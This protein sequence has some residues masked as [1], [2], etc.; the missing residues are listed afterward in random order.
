EHMRKESREELPIEAHAEGDELVAELDAIDQGDRFINGLSGE[1]EV[2]HS[3]SRERQSLPFRQVAPGRYEARG[4]IERQG[5]FMLR[6]VLEREQK[7]VVVARGSFS[8]P[9][10][11][12]LAEL[13]PDP[14]L[15]AAA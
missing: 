14:E 2:V 11:S 13:R 10:P 8:H 7:P 1:L 6:A 3:Q 5:S 9:F 12:E 4:P 15:V